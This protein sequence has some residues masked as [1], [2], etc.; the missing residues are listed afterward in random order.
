M[1]DQA[2]PGGV[3][4]GVQNKPS[5]VLGQP[6]EVPTVIVDKGGHSSATWPLPACASVLGPGSCPS[7]RVGWLGPPGTVAQPQCH[8]RLHIPVTVTLVR[9]IGDES[10]LPRLVVSPPHE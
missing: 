1:Q 9:A 10:P 7:P 2:L 6:Y 8:G 5:R 3:A 4:I